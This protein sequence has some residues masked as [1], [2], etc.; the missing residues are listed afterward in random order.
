MEK[1]LK[2]NQF[3]S[4]I[5]L[6]PTLC[7]PLECSTPGLPV[8]HQLP[9]FTQTHVHWVSDEKECIYI[10]DTACHGFP[11]RIGRD[12]EECCVLAHLLLLK[13]WATWPFC[14]LFPVKS[15]SSISWFHQEILQKSELKEA[16]E[17]ALGPF[18]NTLEAVA[19]SC[20][21]LLPLL[22]PG[23]AQ[24]HR[25]PPSSGLHQ[26]LPEHLPILHSLQNA[27]MSAAQPRFL[28]ALKLQSN[29]RRSCPT[30]VAAIPHV[31]NEGP[32]VQRSRAIYIKVASQGLAGPACLSFVI[33]HSTIYIF[34]K[35][36]KLSNLFG[37][38]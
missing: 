10:L 23:T 2:K 7:G 8:H 22:S 25:S 14:T 29:Y 12:G 26:P 35:R 27:L 11:R 30:G 21:K 34:G 4:V 24:L 31:A 6:C 5:Q 15:I 16:C 37:R 1:N 13:V 17:A 20:N 36:K 9:E 32:E 18:W 38:W 19:L 28:Q 3:S 33:V